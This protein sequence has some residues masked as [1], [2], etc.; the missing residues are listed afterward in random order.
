MNRVEVAAAVAWLL[1]AEASYVNGVVLPVD[2]GHTQ[3]DVATVTFGRV[4]SA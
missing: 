1:S 3:V 4:S 2:G